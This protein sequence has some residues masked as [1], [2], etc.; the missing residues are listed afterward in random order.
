MCSYVNVYMLD[1]VSTSLWD[2][3]IWC[4]PGKGSPKWI[5]INE[6]RTLHDVL[7]EHNFIIQGIPGEFSIIFSKSMNGSRF[8]WNI[9]HRSKRNFQFVSL[10]L[11]FA[12][13]QRNAVFYVVS[14]S[15]SFYEEFKAGKWSPPP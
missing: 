4:Y 6:K 3:F 9:Y 13:C 10:M 2:N 8:Y 7:K 5:K 1:S 15:S 14:K 12:L 11:L